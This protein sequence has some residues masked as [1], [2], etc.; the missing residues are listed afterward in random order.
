MS[1]SYNN[2]TLAVYMVE[3]PK[4]GTRPTAPQSTSTSRFSKT[5][6]MVPEIT[7]TPNLF[8]LA[9]IPKSSWTGTEE[10]EIKLK[11]NIKTESD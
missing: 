4:M 9:P 1:F 6:I 3:Y 8:R 2:R 10:T 5:I 7:L 11:D